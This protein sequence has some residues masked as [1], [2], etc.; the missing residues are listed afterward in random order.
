MNNKIISFRAW[1]IKE[2]QFVSSFLSGINMDFQTGQLYSNGLN[3]T[4]QFIL[5]QYVGVEDCIN[6]SIYEG[7]LIQEEDF[8]D[9]YEVRKVGL[10]YYRVNKKGQLFCTTED[11]LKDSTV[12]GNIFQV[13]RE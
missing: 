5:S 2:K 13:V 8:G 10:S 12:I 9:I 7:D 4:D 6:N 1:N 3:I 11:D